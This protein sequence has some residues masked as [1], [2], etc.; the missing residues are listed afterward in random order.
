M[1]IMIWNI[2]FISTFVTLDDTFHE[3]NQQMKEHRLSV[4]KMKIWLDFY[5]FST[6][7]LTRYLQEEPGTI[8]RVAMAKV[9]QMANRFVS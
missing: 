5:L 3:H 7:I 9:P 8:W 2:W 4:D 6:E 1:I